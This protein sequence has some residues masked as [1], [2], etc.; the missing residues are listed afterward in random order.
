MMLYTW[1]TCC[2][3]A[4][5][6]QAGKEKVVYFTLNACREVKNTIFLPEM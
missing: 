6:E 2:Q 1:E 4:K 3:V 5:R